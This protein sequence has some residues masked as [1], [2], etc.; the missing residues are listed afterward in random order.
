MS[1][2]KEMCTRL[3]LRANEKIQAEIKEL[4]VKKLATK[5]DGRRMR[6][7]FQ[8]HDLQEEMVANIVR[9]KDL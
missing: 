4:E 1:L 3:V 6:L 2:D 7:Q 5:D 8:I 9:L